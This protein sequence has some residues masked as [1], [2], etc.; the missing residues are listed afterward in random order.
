MSVLAN[1]RAPVRAVEAARPREEAPLDPRPDGWRDRRRMLDACLSA[2]ED[3]S[4]QGQ[5]YVSSD[6][7][8]LVRRAMPGIRA[9]DVIREAIELVFREQERT[10][11][12]L[13]AAVIVPAVKQPE[14][15]R[16]DE[17]RAL[18]EQIKAGLHAT[19][20]LLLEAHSKHVWQVLG[21]S[22]WEDYVKRE[23]NF[24]RSRSYQLLDHG[25]VLRVLMA[26]AKLTSVPDISAYAAAQILPRLD[27]VATA[28]AG[29]VTPDMD[30]R[31]VRQ[32][33]HTVVESFRAPV[34]RARETVALTVL[35]DVSNG[36]D[37]R[38]R[39]STTRK[40]PS[41]LAALKA[42]IEQALRLPEAEDVFRW[43]DDDDI[44]L[45][46]KLGDAAAR[47][48]AL[49]DAWTRRAQAG[50]HLRLPLDSDRVRVQNF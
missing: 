44:P 7:A 30:E 23:F 42:I 2:L 21:Y 41:E 33:I 15:L 6:L 20:L 40:D 31:A 14:T 43:V 19:T 27:E 3:E 1:V 34:P 11:R 10:C 13:Q 32:S 24:S 18:T 28:V 50:S 8:S 47:L 46:S 5:R 49:A 17:A 25:R 16:R 12:V 39:A 26:S 37:S 38:A 36:P 48:T 45:L 35:A 22:T 9:G 4:E 29:S